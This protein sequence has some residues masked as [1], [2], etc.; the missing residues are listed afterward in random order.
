MAVDMMTWAMTLG[1]MRKRKVARTVVAHNCEVS[2]VFL[3]LDHNHGG[4]EPI[5][6]ETMVFGGPLDS[7]SM[8]YH[9]YDQAEAGHAATVIEARKACEQIA[10]LRRAARGSKGWRRHIRRM[11][12][13]S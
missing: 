1:N 2:T 9:T 3:G 4:G 11:K 8:R 10:A 12:R 6:F 7:D 13:T 5:L